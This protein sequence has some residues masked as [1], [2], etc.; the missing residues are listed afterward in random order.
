M[1]GQCTRLFLALWPDPAVRG[2]LCG[3]RDAW[4]WP[5]GAAPVATGKLHL[6][7]HFLGDQPSERVPGLLAGL[8]VPFSP[9]RF[10]LGMPKVWPHG[11]AVLEPFAEPDELLQLHA[12]LASALRA[13]GLVP[14][15]RKFRPHVTMARRAGK[16]LPPTDW[17]PLAW[18][19]AGYTLVES[20]GGTY[21]VL[22]HYA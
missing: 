10:D 7:L 22:K 8:A 2:A 17:P 19:I 21:T 11:I 14:E 18:D 6:T 15:A 5:R 4:T 16:A 3:W 13:L 12:D 9:F 1:D 20:L